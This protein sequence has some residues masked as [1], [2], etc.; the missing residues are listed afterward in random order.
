MPRV[1]IVVPVYNGE[2]DLFE[3]LASILAQT[4]S[5]WTAVVVNNCSTDRTGEIADYFA[6]KD[7]RFRVE[8]CAEFL[9]QSGNYNRAVDLRAADAEY[10]KM[11]EA[12][13]WLW[14]ECLERMVTLADRDHE[15]RLVGCYWLHGQALRGGG[16][17]WPNEVLDGDEARRDH[18][19]TDWCYYFGTPTTLLF[20]AAALAPLSP[21]FQP[22]L[23]FDDVDLCFRVLRQWKF[24]FVHQILAF[25]RDDN[26]GVSEAF[27]NFDYVPAY[28]YLLARAYGAEMFDSRESN[29]ITRKRKS[30]YHRRLGRS[31]VVGR[32]KQYW[33]FHKKAWGL[34]NYDLPRRELIWPVILELLDLGFNLKAT[35]NLLI[36]KANRLLASRS[37]RYS[38]SGDCAADSQKRASEVMPTAR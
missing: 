25:L 3:C 6:H 11:V 24:G 4:Y 14:P 26:G 12:D 19:R 30:A 10:V 22:G 35:L 5:D 16:A 2:T 31:L 33:D 7:S 37:R 36:R 8:H 18:L 32:P 13:N 38:P 1:S 20:R 9:S 15:I 34:M 23:F 28:Q 27:S 17:P 21:C 29:E